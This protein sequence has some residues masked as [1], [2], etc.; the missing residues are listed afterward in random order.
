V[1]LQLDGVHC[2]NCLA[3]ITV[4]GTPDRGPPAGELGKP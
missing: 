3:L 1:Q 2:R 4:D